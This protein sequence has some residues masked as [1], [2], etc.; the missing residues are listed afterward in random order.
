[1]SQILPT[2][3]Q[4][5]L[6]FGLNPDKSDDAVDA[7]SLAYMR[8]AE[9]W[10]LILD[11]MGGTRAMRVAGKRW[12]PMEQRETELNYAARLGR[13]VLYGAFKDTV[14]KLSSKPFSQPITM[15]E[16]GDSEVIA[17]LYENAD[18]QGRTLTA[19]ARDI[20]EDG[21]TYGL[22]HILV[23]YPAIGRTLTLAEEREMGVR[24]YFCRIHPTDL[25]GWKSEKGSSGETMLTEI[26]FKERGVRQTGQFGE[27]VTERVRVISTDAFAVYEKAA[28]ADEYTLIDEGTH[29][30]GHI[31]LVTFYCNRT[32]FME[33]QPPL[34]D[35]AWLNLAHWQSLSDQRNILRFARVGILF[36]S[37]LL[38]EEVEQG[39]SIG[40]TQLISS[41]NPEAKMQYV[42][43]SGASVEAGERDLAQLEARMETLGLA[44]FMER[45]GRQTAT[46]R[47]LDEARTQSAVQT[48]IRSL[49]DALEHAM[50]H[51]GHWI[52]EELPE[53][54]AINVF[55]D[56]SVSASRDGDAK[57]LL[58]MRKSGMISHTTFLHE[59]K[60]RGVLADS[61]DPEAEE[62]MIGEEALGTIREMTELVDGELGDLMEE[63]ADEEEGEDDG[64]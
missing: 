56:F 31:P 25:I 60:R 51:A 55:S 54:F 39:I 52:G 62:D 49:E 4:S 29:T 9:A 21:V 3:Y 57:L 41:S 27:E 17:A 34:E 2:P 23:D 1:M 16:A 37:G 26:R 45:T 64:E 19:F 33:A 20:Y 24:P 53:D 59:I 15:E 36:A 61:V 11:L 22:G 35:L 42:E 10:P 50:A 7:P 58:D 28:D 14:L 47:V 5:P 40:P 32:E 12:L 43:H 30:M 44:P 8:M 63:M 38:D 48:W 46:G 18:M 6:S 13:S